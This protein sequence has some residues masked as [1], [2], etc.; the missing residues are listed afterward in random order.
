M[1]SI[2]TTL[3]EALA[4]GMRSMRGHPDGGH[5]LAEALEQAGAL[6]GTNKTSGLVI[7]NKRAAPGPEKLLKV[8]TLGIHVRAVVKTAE[9]SIPRMALFQGA[10]FVC[11]V[12]E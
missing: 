6:T 11:L 4:A 5:T 10:C 2:V 3:K 9:Q 1:A 8:F 12:A 7:V